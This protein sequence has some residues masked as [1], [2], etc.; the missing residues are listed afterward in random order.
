MTGN[1]K[2]IEVPPAF[3]WSALDQREVIGSKDGD[4]KR[5]E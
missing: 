4:A 3:R 2:I 5:T 1:E